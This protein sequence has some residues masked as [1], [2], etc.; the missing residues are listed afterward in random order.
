MDEKTSYQAQIFANRLSR[1]YKQ[2]RKWARRER[3]TCYRLYD[4]DIPEVP[5]AADLYEFLPD[6]V[7]SKEDAMRAM[8]A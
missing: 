2:L 8:F 6:G 3:V 7:A 1:S 5:L 4:R